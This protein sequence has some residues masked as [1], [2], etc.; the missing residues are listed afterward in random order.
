[1][2]EYL[3]LFLFTQGL[4]QFQRCIREHSELESVQNATNVNQLLTSRSFDV[5]RFHVH[6]TS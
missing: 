2:Y 3:F 4:S 5:A 1:M 6:L